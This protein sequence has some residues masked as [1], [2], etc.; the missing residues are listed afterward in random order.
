MLLLWGDG[1]GTMVL[2]QVAYAAATGANAIIYA[3]TYTAVEKRQYPKATAA[4]FSCGHIGN[5]VGSGIGELLIDVGK[6]PLKTLF[7]F[8]WAFTTAGLAAFVLLYTRAP[9]PPPPSPP[10]PPPPLAWS[11]SPLSPSPS[12][13]ARTPG[14]GSMAA[15]AM[16]NGMGQLWRE[17]KVLYRVPRVRGWSAWWVLGYS[18]YYVIGN[19]YQNQFQNIDPTAPLGAAE[20]GIE[21]SAVVGSV[22]PVVLLACRGCTRSGSRGPNGAV[23]AVA[24]VGVKR[25]AEIAV[26]A[27]STA[28]L[29][30][31]YLLSTKLQ[32]SISFSIFF[33]AVAFGVHSGLF[34]YASMVKD[35]KHVDAHPTLP[36]FSQIPFFPEVSQTC[37][38]TSC[39]VNDAVHTPCR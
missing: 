20:I 30:T 39:I 19:Y 31:V 17:L 21:L 37:L 27:A 9:E 24:D 34:A 4:V 12:T 1:V 14:P 10:P 2:M 35:A 7:Y 23:G 25:V 6:V 3:A 5:V 32:S 33:N 8:S 15:V 22:A 28:G 18:Q 36:C 38:L 13:A 11:S 26:V 29:G 16:Q